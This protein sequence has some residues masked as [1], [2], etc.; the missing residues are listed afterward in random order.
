MS[1]K[2]E[3]EGIGSHA[4]DCTTGCPVEYISVDKWLRRP[5]DV[6]GQ[7]LDVS[8]L[9]PSQLKVDQASCSKHDREYYVGDLSHCPYPHKGD[10]GVC[11][12]PK[13]RFR[14]T[15]EVEEMGNKPRAENS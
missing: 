9:L 12:P 2:R 14:I 4:C 8:K 5:D 13:F 6:K 10:T 15:V 3:F 7:S 1:E 11:Q